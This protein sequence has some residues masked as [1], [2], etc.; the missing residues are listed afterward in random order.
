MR[1]VDGTNNSAGKITY[2][3]E[4]NVYYKGHIERIKMDVCD[5]EKRNVILGILWLQAYNPEINWET[6]EVKMTRYLPLC[7]RNMKL[8]EEKKAKGVK[9]VA[10]IE[11]KKIVR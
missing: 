8:K 4:V 9:R 10:M 1:N 7:G 11:E 6:E 2:Q 5:L 3:V